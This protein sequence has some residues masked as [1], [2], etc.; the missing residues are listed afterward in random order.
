VRGATRKPHAGANAD[1]SRPFRGER[2]S[3]CVLTSCRRL[4]NGFLRGVVPGQC[5]ERLSLRGTFDRLPHGLRNP[6][7][8][9]DLDRAGASLM[10]LRCASTSPSC[11]WPAIVSRSIPWAK[12][13]KSS[14]APCGRRPGSR[15]LGVARH[16]SGG[17]AWSPV[18]PHQRDRRLCRAPRTS[19]NAV[20][21]DSE[22]TIQSARHRPYGRGFGPAISVAA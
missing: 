13:R 19:G 3:S 7:A 22:K 8:G 18:S 1:S 14:V 9:D 5:G 16:G 15:A 17:K 2:S 10:V 12:T 21:H 11:R 6:D 4:L 20:L